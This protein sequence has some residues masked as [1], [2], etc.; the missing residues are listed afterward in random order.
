MLLGGLSRKSSPIAACKIILLRSEVAGQSSGLAWVLWV[1][2]L[3]SNLWSILNWLTCKYGE[4]HLFSFYACASSVAAHFAGSGG[5]SPSSLYSVAFGPVLK[6]LIMV[7]VC[8]R[9]SHSPLATRNQKKKRKG[10]CPSIPPSN[11]QPM[12]QWQ[13]F[14]KALPSKST[15]SHL[16]EA[17][18][19]AIDKHMGLGNIL[20]LN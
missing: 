18:D 16:P 1:K 5:F 14:Q 4:V 9:V 11:P 17:E 3:Y 6:Q 8:G 12:P 7:E 15:S 19:Q 2:V 20:D 13:N 10:P